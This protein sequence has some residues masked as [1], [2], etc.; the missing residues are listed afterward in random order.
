M[1]TFAYNVMQDLYALGDLYE[2]AGIEFSKVEAGTFADYADNVSKQLNDRTPRT[3]DEY[4]TEFVKRMN[5]RVDAA[6][7]Y[8]DQPELEEF[9]TAVAEYL[10]TLIPNT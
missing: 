10:E 2:E 8:N 6:I 1:P 7:K 4:K 3:A 5:L 9:H